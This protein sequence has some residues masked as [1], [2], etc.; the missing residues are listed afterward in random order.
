MATEVETL[1]LRL[2]VSQAKFEK[3]LA[4]ANQSAKKG[5]QD[6]QAAFDKINPG[7]GIEAGLKRMEKAGKG[8]SFQTANLAAQLQDIA[9][10]LRGGTNPF[11]IALQQGTQISA[12]L[13]GMG[14]RGAVSALGGAFASLVNPVSLATIAI[15]SL[16]G[17]AVQ[18]FSQLFT[19]SDKSEKALKEQADL[20]DRVAAKWGEALPSLKAYNDEIKKRAD[21]GDIKTA[22]SAAAAS[23]Y[24]TLRKLLPEINQ[25]MADLVVKMGAMGQTDADVMRL[26]AAFGTFS[27]DVQKSQASVAQLREVQ[28][29]LANV[30]K[31]TG[32]PAANDMADSIGRLADELERAFEAS[33]KLKA[34][35]ALRDFYK[36]S[37]LG[38]L[39][40]VYSGGGQFLNEQQMMDFKASGTRS[41]FEQ[42]LDKASGAIEGFVNRVFKA[43]G[44]A[45]NPNSSAN[46]YG[47]FITS[48][49]LRL[50]K[51]HFPDRAKGMTDGAILAMRKNAD[52]ARVLVEAYARENARVLQAAGVSVN[53]AALQLAHFLGAGDAAKVLKAAP[54]TPLAGLISPAAIKANP[55]VLGGNRTVDD[56]I[57]YARR[58]ASES[59]S[60]PTGES[61]KKL[62]A[63]IF[64]GNMQDVQQRID[65]LNA[66]YAAQA[67]L[68]PLV[69]DY[70][71]ALEK[72]RIKQQL[73]TQAQEAGLKVT[74]ELAAKIDALAGNYA[75]A[76]SASDMLSEAQNRTQEQAREFQDMMKDVFSGFVKDL[77]A[78]K[79]ATEALGNALDKVIDRLLNSAI[80]MLFGGLFG[81]LGGGGGGGLFKLFGFAKG[82]I[83]AN[84][85][86]QPLPR[87]ANGGVSRS[88]AIFGEAGPEAAVP[89]PDGRSIPVKL[90]GARGGGETITINLRDD[91]GRMAD[92][93]DQRIQT[94][95]GTIVRVAVQHGQ[96]ATRAAM[97]AMM[98]EA[99]MRSL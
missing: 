64:A 31:A 68:N 13:G 59:T 19:D 61:K 34:E 74:P 77:M 70:G 51:Q 27:D 20:I 41:Q 10:Q 2:E 67:Q 24:D 33:S 71:F 89:L 9:V 28:G 45:K 8:A 73:L 17:A 66:E 22:V 49:W 76:A 7:T 48:T 15:I 55:T 65:L 21:E 47:Q 50:F 35:N 14:A 42:E 6:V 78:G 46:G 88:A 83:A 95:S 18:Y 85:R 11:T 93:A 92:I 87:F 4:R 29:A 36:Q 32:I 30:F 54:G 43:E 98:A 79:S 53:E 1:L 58:R 23:Q 81:G 86:P 25:E 38:T 52:T 91:S 90:M 39:G 57:A 44:S 12:V 94:A 84:G 82:G 72:A 96:K 37:P 56:A 26:Q 69:N 75:K 63:E 40:P 60:S 97:P 99:Q 80:D 5:A 62:P 3:Q 16:G